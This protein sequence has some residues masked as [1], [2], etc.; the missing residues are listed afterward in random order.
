L[1][2]FS[3]SPSIT[4]PVL[5]IF[6]LNLILHHHYQRQ[7]QTYFFFLQH[8]HLKLMFVLKLYW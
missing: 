6:G 3:L 4:D 7:Q 8:Y 1:F 2:N 5:L